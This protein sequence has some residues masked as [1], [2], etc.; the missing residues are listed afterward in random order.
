MQVP[1][2]KTIYYGGRKFKEGDIIPN[3]LADRFQEE[4]EQDFE[5]IKTLEELE[6]KKEVKKKVKKEEKPKKKRKYTRRKK[7]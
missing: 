4:P 6:E 7:K 3:F 5:F 1:K 2:G